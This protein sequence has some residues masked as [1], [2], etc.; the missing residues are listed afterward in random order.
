MKQLE[1]GV[2]L[3]LAPAN[4][5]LTIQLQLANERLREAQAMASNHKPR[6]AEDS[7][8][9]FRVVVNDAAAGLK[10]SADPKVAKALQASHWFDLT[11]ARRDGPWRKAG[12]NP[13]G[14]Q[15]YAAGR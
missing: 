5:R 11:A 8:R 1:E 13:R 12:A 2:R 7:L 9:A 15:G 6:L 4:E 14:M 3:S 10:N